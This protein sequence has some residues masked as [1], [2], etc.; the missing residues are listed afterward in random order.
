MSQIEITFAKLALIEQAE[1]LLDRVATMKLPT[2]DV[3]ASN[4][5]LLARASQLIDRATTL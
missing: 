5:A 1:A 4:R 3:L 2:S